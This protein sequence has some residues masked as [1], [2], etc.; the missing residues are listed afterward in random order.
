M[1]SLFQEPNESFEDYCWRV[2]RTYRDVDPFVSESEV[3]KRIANSVRK[4]YES[5]LLIKT[6][7]TIAEIIEI[8]KSVELRLKK[9]DFLKNKIK[10]KEVLNQSQ[11]YVANI[12]IEHNFDNFSV[13]ELCNCKSMKVDFVTNNEKLQN[14][15]NSSKSKI[16]NSFNKSK[17]FNSEG[18]LTDEEKERR[19]R[20]NLCYYCASDKHKCKDC[21]KGIKVKRSKG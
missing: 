11:Y 16:T 4:E 14:K 15:V 1:Y 2:L 19:H 9:H 12:N 5:L 20:D 7:S 3:C 17:M 8:G 10:A 21:L 6:F 18:K 13:D